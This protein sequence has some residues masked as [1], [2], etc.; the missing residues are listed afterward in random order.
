[1]AFHR[2]SLLIRK[3]FLFN[4][5]LFAVFLVFS[6]AFSCCVSVFLGSLLYLILSPASFCTEIIIAKKKSRV[7]SFHSLIPAWECKQTWL[8]LNFV[9]TIDFT[10]SQFPAYEK[11]QYPENF[12]FLILKI[13]VLVTRKVCK[14][15]VYKH[16]KT[17]E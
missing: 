16:T 10:S 5:S 4:P 9:P 11:R 15:F 6:L 1:M 12:A 17:I 2:S 7:I 8:L 14:M 3:S 13:L